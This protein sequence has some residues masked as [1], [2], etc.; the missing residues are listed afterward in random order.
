MNLNKTLFKHHNIEG[1]L[2]VY[3][4]AK[5][6]IENAYTD[7]ESAKEMLE[8][9][10]IQYVDTLPSQ[11]NRYRKGE[12][13]TTL[14]VL[15]GINTR[16]WR[17]I[18]DLMQIQKF[19]SVKKADELEDQ[20]QEG[21]FPELTY[22]NIYNTFLIIMSQAGEFA[23]AQIKESY[24]WL[25]PRSANSWGGDYKT[26]DV[27]QIGKKVI[28]SGIERPWSGQ[29]QWRVNHYCRQN[30]VALDKAFHT[31]DGAPIPTNTYSMPF[32]SAIEQ[33]EGSQPEGETEYFKF[34][35]YNNGNIH[36]TFKR[37]D[38]VKEFNRVAGGGML[39]P[40]LK[41]K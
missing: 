9:A 20:L 31:L 5:G 3:T 4:E 24:D 8:A 12:D 35:L 27:Y 15:G 23:Q 6:M 13:T 39:K 28:K 7:L 14:Q 41:E 11:H 26:N 10:G 29:G 37:M 22:D 36:I 1:L 19:L 32:P 34:K 2:A 38:L 33:C 17:R 21:K 16:I 30:F 40:N 25:R 18:I